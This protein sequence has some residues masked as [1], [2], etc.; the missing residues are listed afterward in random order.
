[1]TLDGYFQAHPIERLGLLKIDVE[2]R[3]EKGLP[4]ARDVLRCFRR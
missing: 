1:M 3:E 2:G 4:G